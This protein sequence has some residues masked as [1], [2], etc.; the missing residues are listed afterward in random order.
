MF[1]QEDQGVQQVSA[2]LF[3]GF[4]G[5]VIGYLCPF[6]Q[7]FNL[8]QSFHFH[9]FAPS[10]NLDGLIVLGGTLSPI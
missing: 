2:G 7:L 1:F 10:C 4:P 9:L 6:P 8:F 3:Q 5:L